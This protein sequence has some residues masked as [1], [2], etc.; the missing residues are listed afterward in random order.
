MR[1]TTS[2]VVLRDYK[3]EANRRLTLLTESHGVIDAWANGANHTRSRLSASTEL[4]CYSDLQLFAY[5]GRYT[6]DSASALRIFFGIREHLEQLALA[7]YLAVLTAELAPREEEA[8]VYLRLLL[9]TLHMLEKERR[10][11]TQLKAMYE[12]RLLTLA[13][14]MPDLVACRVCGSYEGEMLFSPLEGTLCC[15]GCL[16]EEAPDGIPISPGVLAALRHI[17]YSSPEK[18]FSFSLSQEGLRQLAQVCEE[19]LQSQ[20]EKTF[21]TLEFYHAITAGLPPTA[22]GHG[23]AQA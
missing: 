18:L 14:Y 3:V 6:V 4:L 22:A 10:P 19:Y 11:P 20:L 12:L 7:S 5:R 9:N 2:G 15:K 1:L 13:G 23:D 16:Q 17:T 21:P 8:G